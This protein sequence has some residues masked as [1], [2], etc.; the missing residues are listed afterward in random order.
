MFKTWK[1]SI[2]GRVA[3]RRSAI[4]DQ[5]IPRSLSSRVRKVNRLLSSKSRRQIIKTTA[6]CPSTSRSTK[7]KL[8][9]SPRSAK[10]CALRRTCPQAWCRCRSPNA[11]PL[12]SNLR[13]QS[14]NFKA[15]CKACPFRCARRIF[16]RR[17]ASWR[18]ACPRSIVVSPRS[19]VKSSTS[20]SE[21]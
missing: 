20:K 5:S 12:S 21:N 8:Q 7:K 1:G 11:W 9:I 3:A 18:N 4:R 6:R 15:F 17:S 14:A 13:A 16:V 2:E 19:P 10:S